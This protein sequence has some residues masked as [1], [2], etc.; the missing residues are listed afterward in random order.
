M[1]PTSRT[2]LSLFLLFAGIYL[3]TLRGT[4]TSVDDIPR[5]NLTNALMTK[6]TIEIPRSRM[7][8]ATSVDG[9]TYSKYG[10]GMSLVMAPLWLVGQGLDKTASEALR[11]VMEQ[12]PIFAMSTTN[13]WLGALA[14]ALLFLI[15]RRVGFCDRT[16]LLV[17]LTTGLGSML[18]LSAQTSFENILVAVLIEIVAL[19]LIGSEPTMWPAF[20]GAGAAM[21]FVFLTRWADGWIFLP[22]AVGLL[23]ARLRH[24]VGQDHRGPALAVAFA[25]PLLLGIGLAMAYN[26]ARFLDPFELGYDDDNTSWRF[27]PRGVFGF[28]FSPAKSVFIF[29]P[30]LVLAIA[31]FSRLWKRIGGG[32]RAAG[33]FWMIG[34]PLLAY[35]CFE[36]WDGGWCFGPRYLLPSVVLAMVALG[37]WI[38]DERWREGLWRP[39]AFVGLF[40][41][42]VYAQWVCLA[43][44]FNDYSDNYYFF[45]YYPEAC[46]LWACLKGLCH[47]RENLWLLKLLASSDLR[48]T[49][50]VILLIPLGFIS[51]GIAGLRKELFSTCAAAIER[52]RESAPTLRTIV[53]LTAALVALIAL[54]KVAE[55]AWRKMQTPAGSGLH[56]DYHPNTRWADPVAESKCDPWLDFDWSGTGRPFQGDFSVRWEGSIEAPTGGTYFFALDACGTATLSLDDQLLIVN[57]WPQPGRRMIVRSIPLAG[58]RHSIRLEFASSPAVDFYGFNGT[59]FGRTRFAPTG[60]RLRWKPPGALFL[61]TVPPRVLRPKQ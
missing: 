57:Y 43:S 29:T 26:H 28:L 19:A 40:A 33:F 50:V 41:V 60:L 12:P 17:A 18:W 47:P 7:V 42:G 59:F 51:A 10:I 16:A 32:P 36:T 2:S 21:G 39:A 55:T 13:Q 58:G 31:R 54:T 46:P 61:R 52:I 56:A 44:N 3:L 37:E 30:L 20:A 24:R 8:A 53:L 45:R 49:R 35:S 48:L 15:V 25:G 23:I 6:G 1:A 14:C 34:A 11:Q 22:G 9:R 27:L 4:H 5:Y 38:E